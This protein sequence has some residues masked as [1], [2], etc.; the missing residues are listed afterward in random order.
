MLFHRRATEL[1]LKGRE[2]EGRREKG[3]SL[4]LPLLQLSERKGGRRGDEAA[5]SE[6]GRRKGDL[7]AS[8]YCT[9]LSPQARPKATLRDEGGF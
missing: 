1:R 3:V 8:L 6:R 9:S 4:S 7:S 5:A 2:R